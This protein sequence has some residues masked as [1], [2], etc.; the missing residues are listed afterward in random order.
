MR[1]IRVDYH[2]HPNLPLFVPVFGRWLREWKAYSIWKAFQKYK[3]DV[4]FVAEHSYKN[5]KF[6]FEVLQSLRPKGVKTLLVPAI[7]V[8]TKEG[9]DVMVFAKDPEHIYS[10]KELLEPEELTLL[11]LIDYVKNDKKLRGIVVHP[12]MLGTTSIIDN[13]GEKDTHKAIKEFGLL[14]MHNY[15]FDALIRAMKFLRLN[16]TFQK[17]Y[18]RILKIEKVPAEF[19]HKGVLFTGGSDAHHAAGVGDYMEIEIDDDEDLF[20]AVTKKQG[21][22]RPKRKSM[23]MSFIGILTPFKEFLVKRLYLYK[24]FHRV[25]KSVQKILAERSKKVRAKLSNPIVKILAKIG[26]TPNMLSYLGV[27]SMLAFILFIQS[28][29]WISFWLLVFAIFVDAFLDGAL[30]RY[31]KKASDKGKFID[32]VCDVTV[33]ALFIVGVNMINLV[34]AVPAILFVYFMFMSKLLM[35][36]KKNIGEQTDWLIHPFAGFFPNMLAGVIYG[37]FLL[38]LISGRNYMN[39]AAILFA[40]ALIVKSILDFRVIISEKL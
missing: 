34:D 32:M 27:L 8:L 5:P 12:F 22:G 20:T 25:E 7:E 28:N 26:I 9:T 16:K 40:A 37:V 13:C 31:L 36:I 14:E 18:S 11:E 39:E 19:L 6:T 3:L 17:I 35:V 4:V 33:F 15:S 10:K 21:I 38:W 30:A 1:K 24:I 2:F 29:P 23:F